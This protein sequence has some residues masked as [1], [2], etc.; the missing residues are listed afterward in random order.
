VRRSPLPSGV[1][2]GPAV[3]VSVDGQPRQAYLGETVAA[4]LMA[5]GDA[6]IRVTRGGSPRG[7]YCGMGVCFDCLVIVDGVPNARACMTWIRDGM[8][9]RHMDG[10]APAGLTKEDDDHA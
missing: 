6:P 10:L 1:R 7:L 8:E 9:I 5:E 2:R 4:A 3:T